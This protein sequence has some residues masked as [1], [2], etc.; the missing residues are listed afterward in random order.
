MYL[1]NIIY[2]AYGIFEYTNFA[3]FNFIIKGYIESSKRIE[4]SIGFEFLVIRKK[5]FIRFIERI[6]RI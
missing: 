6:D 2:P 5:S 1:K 3:I 4:V